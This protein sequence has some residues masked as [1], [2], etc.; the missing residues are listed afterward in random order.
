[1]TDLRVIDGKANEPPACTIIPAAARFATRRKTPAT[2]P[3]GPG[4]VIDAIPALIE[5]QPAWTVEDAHRT[6][7][8]EMKLLPFVVMAEDAGPCENAINYWCDEA[9]KHGH[10][11][12]KRGRLYAQLTLKAIKASAAKAK[13]TRT[14]A[15]LYLEHIFAAI[16]DDAIERRRKGGKGSRTMSSTVNGF[17][18]ELS[19][20]ICGQEDELPSAS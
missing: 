5:A 13:R 14:A 2:L 12:H 7:C 1:M 18:R 16:I 11:D 17:L 19:A 15:P 3:C 10:V 20:H 9:T 6:Y 4:E 8:P